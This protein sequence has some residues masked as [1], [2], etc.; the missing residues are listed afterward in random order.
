MNKLLRPLCLAALLAGAGLAPLAWAADATPVGTWKT[1]D[2]ASG[3]AKSLV[4]ISEVDG[5]LQGKVVKLFDP[6]QPNPTCSQCEGPRKDQPILGMQIL[7]DVA[8]HGEQWDGGQILDPEKGKVY[9]VKLT[10][11]DDGRKL[12][13]RGFLGVSLLGRTQTWLRERDPAAATPSTT[14]P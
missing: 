5:K 8:R 4:T 3:K 11:A 1:I 14:Q 12:H 7:W 9:G 2:D 13:V 6:S 10:L